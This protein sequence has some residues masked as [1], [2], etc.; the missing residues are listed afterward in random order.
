MK[1]KTEG[2]PTGD[3]RES[4]VTHARTAYLDVRRCIEAHEVAESILAILMRVNQIDPI[5]KAG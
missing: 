5:C 2:D 3:R 4:C 1:S